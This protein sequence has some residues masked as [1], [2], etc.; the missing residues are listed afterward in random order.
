MNSTLRRTFAVIAVLVLVGVLL[1]P[2]GGDA[3]AGSVN[4]RDD[5]RHKSLKGVWRVIT[6]P[7]NCATG[8]PIPAAAFEGLF[9]FHKDGAMSVWAQN[10][11]ITATRSPSHGLW[12]REHGRNDYAF[13]FVHLRY[14][15]ATGVFLGRQ[16]SSGTLDLGENGDEFTS[17][18]FTV[19]FDA[20]GNPGPPGCANSVGI[21][22]EIDE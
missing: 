20:N 16:E 4:A 9:T 19:V 2:F 22:F 13:K 3:A 5:E 12:R 1:P 15:L 11:T 6:T 7:R 10:A 14:H 8:V 17:D 18:S 21:R